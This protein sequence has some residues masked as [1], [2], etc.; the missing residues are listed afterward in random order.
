MQER[1]LGD[2]HDFI[3]YAL[4]RHLHRT[5]SLRIGVNWYLTDPKR[6]DA[7]GN[8][9]G[10]KRHHLTHPEWQRLDPELLEKLRAYEAPESRSI[11][12]VERD[13]ILP[14]D[15]VY[16]EQEVADAIGRA[17]WHASALKHLKNTDIIFLDPDIGFEVPSMQQSRSPKYAF[18]S[19]AADWLREGKVCISIQFT[20]HRD[21][22]KHAHKVRDKMHEVALPALKLPVVRGR[23]APNIL[24]LALSPDSMAISIQRAFVSFT[25]LCPSKIELIR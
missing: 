8:N 2:S 6:V 18:Y 11:K 20:P 17:T 3:K 4:L 16:F 5:T 22:I 25:E 21:P 12:N 7:V 23:V 1:Y 24:F 10:E 19:E 13:Q 14:S 9:H 15:T